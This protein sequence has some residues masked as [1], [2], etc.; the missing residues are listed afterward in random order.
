MELKIDEL[1]NL[2]ANNVQ[3][4]TPERHLQAQPFTS[5]LSSS[6]GSKRPATVALSR[7]NESTTSTQNFSN[8]ESTYNDVPSPSIAEGST[9]SS[10]P[11]S[12]DLLDLGMM[13]ESDANEFILQFRSL[14]PRFPFV[15]L[16]EGASLASLR[17]ERPFLLLSVLTTITA[18]RDEQLHYVLD[19]HLREELATR[20]FVEGQKS[21]DLLEGL[22]VYLAW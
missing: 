7:E 13:D 10:R 1:L 4:T 16:P 6:G 21:L 12:C 18:Q 19:R 20:V 3:S 11:N 9:S 17:R 14:T 15:I 8:P 2:L 22:L 5:T